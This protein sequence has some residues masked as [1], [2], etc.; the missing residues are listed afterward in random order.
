[1]HNGFTNIGRYGPKKLITYSKEVRGTTIR[2]RFNNLKHLFAINR[3]EKHGSGILSRG[4]L[5]GKRNSS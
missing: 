5:T 4:V 1:M 2:E 3:R